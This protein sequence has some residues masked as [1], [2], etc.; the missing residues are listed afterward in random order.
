MNHDLRLSGRLVRSLLASPGVVHP[1]SSN[2]FAP[3]ARST[4][5]SLHYRG[6]VLPLLPPPSRMRRGN[7]LAAVSGQRSAV[8]SE[9]AI[10]IE[11]APHRP[12]DV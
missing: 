11:P 6:V 4:P 9:P 2:C 12:R 5:S 8:S 7:Q 3:V 10:A 1:S